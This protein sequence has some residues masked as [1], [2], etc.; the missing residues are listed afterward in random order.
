MSAPFPTPLSRREFVGTLARS[1]VAL[2]AAQGLATAAETTRSNPLAYDVGRFTRTDP[3]LVGWAEEARRNV[4]AKGARRL[5]IGPGDVVH[6]AAGNQILRWSS[7]GTLPTLELDAPVTCLGFAPDGA[8][9]AGTRARVVQFDAAGKHL[10]LTESEHARSWF[11]G[12]AVSN[13]HLWIADSGQRVIWQ[14]DRTGKRLGQ[15]GTRQPD[16][17]VPG[18]VVPSP[19][20]DVRL[21]PDGLLRVNNPGRHRMEAYTLNGDFELAWGKPTAAIAGF[22]GCCNPIALALLPD[23]R[24]VTAEKG[25]PRVKVHAADGTLESVVAGTETFP[26]QHRLAAKGEE[27]AR[28]GLDV[29]VDSAGRIHI[30]DRV[31]GDV[32]VMRPKARA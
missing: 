31:T 17:N 14:H 7:Q 18:F 22:C 30:L 23:G 26:E 6:V 15:L 3:A 29:A 27:G 2:G 25:L 20:L 13:D 9:L 32:R 1:A 21:H 10:L 24:I 12:L 11:S 28:A 19:F 5:A 16:R 4:G 8:L